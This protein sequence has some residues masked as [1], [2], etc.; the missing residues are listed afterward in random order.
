MQTRRSEL[1]APRTSA[2]RSVDLPEP[3]Y[4]EVLLRLLVSGVCASEVAEWTAGPGDG[5]G[6]LALGHEPVGEVVATGPDVSAVRPGDVVTGRVDAS[7]ADHTIA[8]ARD[9][10]VVPPG[11]EPAEALG[12]PLGCVVEALRRTR[13]DT[14]DRVAV[15]G[16]GFMGLVLLQLLRH[17][18]TRQV[19]AIDPRP[20]ARDQALIHGADAVVA[21]GEAAGPAYADAFDVVVEASGTAPGLDLATTLVRPHGV[22]SIM[23]YHQ[24]PR[25]VDLKTWNFKSIDVVNAHVRDRDRLRDSVRRGLDLVAAGRINVGALITHRFALDDVDAAFTALVDKAPGFV[26]A[27][28]TWPE[29]S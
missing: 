23:G 10:V 18:G 27:A 1:T 16:T 28:I 12:E 7:F 24:G 15:V 25:T 13:L 20:D 8:D 19:V 9:L 11:L 17:A 4:G 26:K 14:G 22:L 6:V 5:A 29:P 2:V 21:P 3:G